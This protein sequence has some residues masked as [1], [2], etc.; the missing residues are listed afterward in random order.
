MPGQPDIGWNDHEVHRWDQRPTWC[1]HS[2][3]VVLRAMQNLMCAG[4]RAKPGDHGQFKGVNT[5]RFC[6]RD[7]LPGEAIFD[8]SVNT[9]DLWWFQKLFDAIREDADGDKGSAAAAE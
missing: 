2:D 6:L 1:P 3:C 9:G 5:H 4:R 7:V 8:L